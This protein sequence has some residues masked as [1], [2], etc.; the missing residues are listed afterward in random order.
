MKRLLS[1]SFDIVQE[2]H[3]YEFLKCEPISS[4][5]GPMFQS[6]GFTRQV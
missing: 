5:L 2:E 4:E 1:I 6:L 3:K